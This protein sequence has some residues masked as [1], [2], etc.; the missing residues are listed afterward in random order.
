MAGYQ[1]EETKT[2][3]N[4]IADWRC[5]KMSFKILYLCDHLAFASALAGINWKDTFKTV[6]NKPTIF[7]Y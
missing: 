3:K 6:E 1:L 4:D 2:E 7:E 5:Y